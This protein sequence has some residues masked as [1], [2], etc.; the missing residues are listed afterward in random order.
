M[1]LPAE[2]SCGIGRLTTAGRDE[3]V[4][5]ACA[6]RTER[7]A[8]VVSG[9]VGRGAEG[10]ELVAEVLDVPNKRL[11]GLNAVDPGGDADRQ[12]VIARFRDALEEIADLYRGE[13]VV[14]ITDGALMN[15][16]IPALAQNLPRGYA[17]DRRLPAATPVRLEVGDDG[18]RCAGWPS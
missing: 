11:S 13:T 3:L 8:V 17:L 1:E 7:V 4:A 16:A 6:L 18:W 15:V 12:E 9:E 5:M 14:V 10:A 2:P